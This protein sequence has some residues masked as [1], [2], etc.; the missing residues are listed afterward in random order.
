MHKTWRF[1]LVAGILAI[2]SAHHANADIKIGLMSTLS[3]PGPTL[4]QDQYDAFMLAVEQ[5]GGKL[6]GYPVVV[7]KKDDQLKPDIGVQLAQE[8]I[9]KDKVDLMTG[10]IFSN[11]MMAVYKKIIDSETIFIGSNAGPSRWPGHSAL[12]IFSRPPGPTTAFMKMVARLRISRAI[13]RST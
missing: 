8:F 11:V 9:E 3:G 5:N 13:K 6:G 2:F 7:I 12:L 1:L 10:V 4:G